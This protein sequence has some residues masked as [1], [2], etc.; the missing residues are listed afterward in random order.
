ME[1]KKT[2]NA[3]LE[4]KSKL[5]LTIGFLVAC[6]LS[7]FAINLK[8]EIV[9]EKTPD[10]VYN[11]SEEPTIHITI[12]EPEVIEPEPLDQPIVEPPKTNVIIE[13]TVVDDDKNKEKNNFT[14]TDIPSPPIKIVQ[15]S[16]ETNGIPKP[17]PSPN[18]SDITKIRD[19]IP[20][21]HV[22][23]KPIF[24]GC[25]GKE[26]KELDFCNSKMAQK[27]LLRGLS[28]PE[29]AIKEDRQGTAYLK[30]IVSKNGTIQNVSISRSSKHKDLDKAASEAVSKIFNRKRDVIIPGK[31]EKGESVNVEYQVPVK[32]RLTE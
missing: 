32:F 12:E 21:P 8:S 28:Y 17:K 26:G 1:T 10:I 29:K 2:P 31:N 23:V 14:P 5:F 4:K 18:K 20:Y 7:Y 25:N 3:S 11:N 13:L 24:P 9:E 19:D 6:T 16:K 22:S 15:G 27:S 30:F